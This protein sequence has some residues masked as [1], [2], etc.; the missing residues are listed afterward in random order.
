MYDAAH[1]AYVVG[2]I[3]G[4]ILFVFRAHMCYFDISFVKATEQ[5]TDTNCIFLVD[6]RWHL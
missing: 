6:S 3:P 4:L 1:A 2:F 5:G